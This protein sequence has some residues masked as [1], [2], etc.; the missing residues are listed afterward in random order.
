MRTTTLF[1]VAAA[2]LI[3]AGFGIWAAAPTNA[4]VPA[5]G[6]GIDPF[7]IHMMHGSS[8]PTEHFVDYSFVFV[9]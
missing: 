6:P 2:A 9:Q 1:A 8:V 4:N 5:T 3:A 7:Q